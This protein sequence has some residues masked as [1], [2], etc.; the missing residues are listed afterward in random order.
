MLFQAQS[1][2]LKRLFSL[3]RGKRDVRALSFELSKMSPQVE[4][5][6][7]QPIPLGVTFPKAQNSKLDVRALG[8]E[9]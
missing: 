5:A 1:S 9:L 6:V 8:F 7:V 4:L 3:K 2:K